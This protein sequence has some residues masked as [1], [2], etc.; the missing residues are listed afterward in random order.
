MSNQEIDTI[1]QKLANNGFNP[2][3][4]FSILQRGF[5][6]NSHYFTGNHRISIESLE[7]NIKGDKNIEFD[8][9]VFNKEL[10]KLISAEAILYNNRG[11]SLNHRTKQLAGGSIKDAIGYILTHNPLE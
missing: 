1:K 5:Y 3:M 11:Y 8:K 7:K 10:R 4:A 2:A 9:R 6:Y